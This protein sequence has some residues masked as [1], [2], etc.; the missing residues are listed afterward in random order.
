VT[1][2]EL[3]RHSGPDRC[4]AAAAARAG[5]Y[6]GSLTYVI[7]DSYGFPG[8]RHAR[9]LRAADAVPADRV[10]RTA[11]TRRAH[12]FPDT[13]TVIV[14]FDHPGLMAAARVPARAGAQEPLEAAVQVGLVVEADGGRGQARRH[15]VEQEP[16]GQVDPAPVRYWWG[17]IP[18][19]R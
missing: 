18:N 17:L 19:S 2:T 7:R 15:A 10:R 16:S 3:P 4:R 12:W 14:P 6:V 9:R 8:R 11:S 13:V 5:R 1:S